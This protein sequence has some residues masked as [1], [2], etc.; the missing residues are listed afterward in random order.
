MLMV[1]LVSFLLQGQL[2][3]VK[4]EYEEQMA[5]IRKEA[6][7][8]QGQVTDLEKARSDAYQRVQA[9]EKALEEANRQSADREAQLQV[10]C[11]LGLL[12]C[13]ALGFCILALPLTYSLLHVCCKLSKFIHTQSYPGLEDV[14]HVDSESELRNCRRNWLIVT[15]TGS[16]W[17]R[18]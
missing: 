15:R 7:D 16:R 12:D 10:C 11:P 13:D 9:A 14:I 18:G 3:K 2:E 17:K 6:E 1:K 8:L 5:A 4:A